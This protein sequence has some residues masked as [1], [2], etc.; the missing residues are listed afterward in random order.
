MR[1]TNGI[2][3][4]CPPPLTVTAV[5][6][7]PNTEGAA[8]K[9][10]KARRLAAF[11]STTQTAAG[12]ESAAIKK[13]VA[14]GTH[15]MVGVF[16]PLPAVISPVTTPPVAMGAA[17]KRT[18]SQRLAAFYSATKTAAAAGGA[19]AMRK[20]AMVGVFL[21]LPAVATRTPST[22]RTSTT[23][24]TGAALKMTKAQRVA[25]F[26]SATTGAAGGGALTKADAGVVKKKKTLVHA[27]KKKAGD[28]ECVECANTNY[29]FRT[30]CGRCELP[31]ATSKVQT[32]LATPTPT[33]IIDVRV[34][35]RPTW[36]GK[37]PVFGAGSSTTIPTGSLSC[38]PE[39]PKRSRHARLE[40]FYKKQIV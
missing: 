11:Y 8:L 31:R 13:G 25:A 23:V 16:L 30:E 2:H 22:T 34:L 26:Y 21:P 29:S 40:A 32:Q 20:Q 7:C 12:M 17:L 4:G 18:S 15:S 10:T 9:M 14:E 28:W 39:G 1:V 38:Y 37:V 24:A 36:L 35:S 3:L 33:I 6:I 27:S 5:K 19:G